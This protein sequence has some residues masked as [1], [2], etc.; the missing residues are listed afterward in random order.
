[1][2]RLKQVSRDEV[3]SAR[4][5]AAYNR[6]FGDRDPVAQPGTETGTPGN[7]WTVFALD[8]KLVELMLDRHEWQSSPQRQ[9]PPLLRELCLTRTG[10]ARGSKF[11][12]SQH[13]KRLRKAGATEEQVAA[14]PAWS[15]APCYSEVERTVLGYADDLVLAGGR[16]SDQRF[17]CLRK[18]LSDV[19]IL[20]LTYMIC[21]YNMSATMSRALRLEYDDFDDPVVEVPVPQARR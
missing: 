14:I 1:M 13:C 4:V 18:F 10:W 19:A 7:W 16:C 6:F 9:L 3:E 15:S 12:Y 8:P 5:L 11:V 20:E 21:T 2:P 17:E